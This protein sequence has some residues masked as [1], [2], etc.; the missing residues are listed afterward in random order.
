MAAG[1]VMTLLQ[2]W[3]FLWPL[4]LGCVIGVP[5]LLEPA[6][7][8]RVIGGVIVAVGI[9]GNILWIRSGLRE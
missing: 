4:A 8:A 3:R 7:G 9:V 1:A 5:Y 6:T 2:F